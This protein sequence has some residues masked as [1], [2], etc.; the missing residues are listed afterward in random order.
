MKKTK[1]TRSLLAACSIVA[2]SAVMYGCV[3]SGGDDPAEPMVEPMEPM[4]EPMPVAASAGYVMLTGAQQDALEVELESG[5]SQSFQIAAGMTAERGGVTFTCDS[6][7]DCTI[8]VTNSL[9]KISAM[10]ESQTLG[11][12]TASSMA[13]GYEKPTHAFAALNPGRST[14]IGN[15]VAVATLAVDDGAPANP[16]PTE[17]TGMGIG[18]SGVLNAD[19][20]GLRSSFDPNSPNA[21]ADGDP[22]T[23]GTGQPNG[24]TG[25]STLTG[26]DDG[27]DASM[28]D[29]APAPDGW[30]MKT[31]FRDWGDTA[32]TGDGGFET[33]A[34]VVKNL[35]DGTPYPFD[36]KLSGKYVNTAA[37]SLYSL[38]VSA[39]GTEASETVAG[40]SVD[41]NSEATAA[42][43][44]AMVFDDDSLV[45]A[46]DQDLNVNT[47]ETFTGSYFDAPGQF[48]CIT[49]TAATA[50]C[51]LVRNDDGTVGVADNGTDS[52]TMMGI[53]GSGRWSFTPDPGAMIT[54]PDQDWMA[55]GAWLTTPD[56]AGGTHRLG[57][58]YNGFD[59]YGGEGDDVAAGFT[60][61]ANS[62]KGSA[63]YSGGATGVYRDGVA[64]GLFTA[65]ATLTANFT[66]PDAA[67]DN[68][69]SG[70]IHD[71][72]GTD[73]AFLGAD[74][75]EMA[76][77]QGRGENDWVVLLRAA[78]LANT[79][80]IAADSMTEGSADGVPWSGTWGGHLFGPDT[81][82]DGDN[83]PPSG[84]AGQFE[85]NTGDPDD[86]G[87]MDESDAVTSVVGAF[88]ATMDMDDDN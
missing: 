48:Q 84:V 30:G 69:I 34:I 78:A 72:R 66:D 81:N 27:L 36:R 61:G 5:T 55:Y 4:P 25:G 76:N 10:W 23:G 2:L 1:L 33:A 57:R 19:M 82:A 35:G 8:T 31:L 64:S 15:L 22:M 14:T 41:I 13:S 40:T 47:S 65:T 88:G 58:F 49:A 71:F 53:Q 56:D 79:G 75:G 9:G 28:S 37:Q 20:A 29:I 12:G 77:P 38:S 80:I 60:E 17:L 73:G 86:D 68:M 51:G 54:V 63:N 7:Y 42:Q 26:A 21:E 18:A 62:L 24:L 85:A 39:A 43:W 83:I 44:A 50:N 70:R 67:L 52:A 16:T 87:T 46:Q 59:V 32:G 6:A 11:D 45:G 3:H 74:T